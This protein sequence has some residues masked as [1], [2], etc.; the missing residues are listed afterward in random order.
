MS[1]LPE[2]YRSP[3]ASNGYM[4]LQDGENRIRILSKPILG[5]EDWHE[6]KPV[7]YKMNEKP[8]KSYDEKKPMKHFWSF[9][10]FN[11]VEERIQIMHVT[12]ASIRKSIETLVKDSDWGDPYGYDIKITKSGSGMETEYTVNPVPHKPVDPYIVGEFKA[13]RCNLQAL[14]TGE[15]PFSPYHENYTPLAEDVKS[16]V[17]PI[18]NSKFIDLSQINSLELL[19]E[20]CGPEVS[21]NIKSYIKQEFS[22]ISKIPCDRYELFKKS[23]SERAAEYSKNNEVPF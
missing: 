3:N 13:N 9:I 2:D 14:F 6:K 19:I 21:E 10:V 8:S 7:R 5:W 17:E 22:E 23:V 4:K 18:P 20:K 1:F 12:Q 11:Y 16:K 15:D